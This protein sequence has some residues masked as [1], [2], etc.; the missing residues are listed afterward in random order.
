M[1][2]LIL[3]LTVALSQDV[4]P[5]DS[6]SLAYCYEKASENY[7]AAAKIG[8]REKVTELNQAIA[9]AGHFPDVSIS[10]RASYQSEVSRFNFPGGPTGPSKD[11]YEVALN[12]QQNIYSGGMVGIRKELEQS[13]GKQEVSTVKVE[14]HKLRAQIDEVYFGILLSQQQAKATGLLAGELRKRLAVIRSKVKN[15]VLLPSQQHTLQAELIKAEQDSSEI[16]SNITAGYSVLSELVGIELSRQV[17]LSLPEIT[18]NLTKRQPKR[19]EYDMF[20]YSRETLEQ[21]E[22]LAE[23]GR[24]P[25]IS[26]FG[27]LGYGRPGLNFLE[28]EFHEYYMAGIRF[29]W[30]I[31]DL[32]TSGREKEVL[33]LQQQRVT[34]EREAFSRQLQSALH[35]LESRMAALRENIERDREIIQL[36]EKVVAET[37][38]QLENGVATATQY[39]TEL[40]R[41]NSAR[42]SLF[43]N[44]IHLAKARSEY[45]TALGGPPGEYDRSNRKEIR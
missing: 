31:K 5:P 6:I 16:Q 4:Q 43:I 39:I 15:G 25:R 35:R 19:P 44:K 24:M 32:I 41:A 1:K 10:G 29:Q 34:R 2:V 13:R 7:P 27:S 14:L 12:L 38:S 20:S 8:I 3:A 28:D 26:A 9:E 21:Q 40:T 18:G 42:L 36:R 45:A 11:Q 37:A 17:Q 23:A 30:S 33:K 22:K